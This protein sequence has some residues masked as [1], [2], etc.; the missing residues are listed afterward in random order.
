MTVCLREY[1]R[2]K[3]TKEG[4]ALSK[5]RI[6]WNVNEDNSNKEHQKHEYLVTFT[7]SDSLLSGLK[8]ALL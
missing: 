8:R 6:N 3:E 5:Y 4:H 7:D 2:E 1:K